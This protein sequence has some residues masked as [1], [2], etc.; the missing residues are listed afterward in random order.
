M[1]KFP[2]DTTVPGAARSV[3]DVIQKPALAAS[4]FRELHHLSGLEPRVLM[5]TFRDEK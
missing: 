1:A 2:L 4:R 3:D 5:C